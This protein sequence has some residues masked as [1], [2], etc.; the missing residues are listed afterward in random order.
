MQQT[1][2][3]GFTF[4]EVIVTLAI[5]TVLSGALLALGSAAGR[6]NGLVA[7]LGRANGAVRESDRVIRDMTAAVLPPYWVEPSIAEE[8]GRWSLPYLHGDPELMLVLEHAE[9]RLSVTAGEDRYV[10]AG[11]V[12][13][14]VK[15]LTGEGR[16]P[17]LCVAITL[18]G[19]RSWTVVG[20]LGGWSL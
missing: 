20:R 2:S 6:I 9:E 11:V 7:A 4:V 14:E 13:C 10:L 1:S 15:L 19:G 12:S 8:G 18:A 16:A 3:S 5:V 17:A